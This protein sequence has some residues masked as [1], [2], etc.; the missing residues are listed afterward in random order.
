MRLLLSVLLLL[1]PLLAQESAPPAPS[2]PDDQEWIQK[3]VGLEQMFRNP[4]DRF[5]SLLF[6]R[7]D[8][9]KVNGVEKVRYSLSSAGLEA[10]KPYLFMAWELGADAPHLLLPAVQV[11]DK[12]VLHCNPDNKECPG[13]PGSEI[14]VALSDR[15]GQPSRFVIADQDEKPIAIGEVIPNPSTVTDHDCTLETVLLRPDATMALVIGHGF[16]PEEDI[17]VISTSFDQHVTNAGEA[18][19]QGAYQTVLLPIA[20]DHDSG[21]TMVT[22]NSSQCELSTQFAWGATKSIAAEPAVAQESPTQAPTA[23]SPATASETVVAP[24]RTA[25]D[26][27]QRAIADQAAAAE[28]EKHKPQL[29]AGPEPADVGPP[30]DAQPT[31][32]APAAP[33]A[34]T[35][36]PDEKPNQT[37][38]APDAT[39]KPETPPATENPPSEAQPEAKPAPADEPAPN[40]D[41]TPAPPPAKPDAPE[42]TPHT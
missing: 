30:A 19:D 8:K 7:I 34:T 3:E 25:T 6:N 1:S 23:T 12:G 15:P 31:P 16:H 38:P 29:H 14:N 11:D 2:A 10:G 36:Q 17:K 41:A 33:S 27:I 37:E 9:V 40:P 13:G 32:E 28:A 24:I 42:Q 18:N 22:M 5:A 20:K 39:A 35:P 4:P 26:Q 21:D